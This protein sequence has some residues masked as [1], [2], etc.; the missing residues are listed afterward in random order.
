MPSLRRSLA[1]CMVV[2][3]YSLCAP[4]IS[5]AHAEHAKADIKLLKDAASALQQSRPDLADALTEYAEREG[6]ELHEMTSE[7]REKEEAGE[8][9]EPKD[10]REESRKY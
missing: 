2:V 9:G 5:W 6:R 3:G 10:E 4:S 8:Q 7:A 1:A